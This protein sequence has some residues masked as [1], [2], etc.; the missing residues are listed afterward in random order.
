MLPTSRTRAP[1]PYNTPLTFRTEVR[2]SLYF[3]SAALLVLGLLFV[4]Y[5]VSVPDVGIMGPVISGVGVLMLYMAW[6]NFWATRAGY[7]HLI[8]VGHRLSVRSSDVFRRH[9]DL[10]ALG[11][12][13]IVILT[14]NKGS[15]R[16]YLCF[17][18]AAGRTNKPHPFTHP[19]LQPFAETVL[20]N[21]YIGTNLH[22]AKEIQRV[23]DERRAEPRQDI[24]LP[25]DNGLARSA[26]R[27]R[28]V[29]TAG[30]FAALWV[31][32]VWWRV[33]P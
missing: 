8:L 11:E 7:P 20:L 6:V 1:T 21:G 10:S 4:G 26:A 30:V 2:P 15:Q 29:L 25:A 19:R 33:L 3:A 12:T 13:S 23:I 28:L 5:A 22:G 9:L 18:P 31:G 32:L 17:M 27:V 16:L 24:A 14:G